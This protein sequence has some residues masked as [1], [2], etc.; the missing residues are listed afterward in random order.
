MEWQLPR[1][2][3]IRA[4]TRGSLCWGLYTSAKGLP[5]SHGQTLLAEQSQ[6]QLNP[7]PVPS[8]PH[9]VR[10]KHPP[11]GNWGPREKAMKYIPTSLPALTS[12]FPCLF[13]DRVGLQ[14]RQN[15]GVMWSGYG[16]EVRLARQTQQA[17]PFMN[18][19]LGLVMAIL[20]PQSSSISSANNGSFL[21][22]L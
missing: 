18:C 11:K 2:V 1:S 3:C 16:T 13:R 17:L 10:R 14:W 6:E 21:V 5:S 22:Q 8:A 19:D 9:P 4:E 15:Y 20:G 7:L 12:G